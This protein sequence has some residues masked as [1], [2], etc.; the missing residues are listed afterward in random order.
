MPAGSA[1]GPHPSDRDRRRVLHGRLRRQPA[2]HLRARRPLRRARHGRRLAC[3]RLHGRQRPRHTR[4]LRRGRAHRHPHRH[5]RQGLRRRQRRLHRRA[6]RGRRLA[7]AALAALPLLQQHPA[8]GRGR[9]SCG[10][11]A[12]RADARAARAAPRECALLPR[13]AGATWLHA[14]AGRA[15]DHPGDAGRCGVG[16]AHGG[17]AAGARRV[18]DRLSYPVVPR[19]EARIR[20]QMSAALDHEQL[21][22]AVAA[23]REVG[24]QLGVIT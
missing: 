22:R 3:H 9:G 21:E 18:R 15:S 2:R 17:R 16:L 10:A 11:R 7:A 6:P 8:G 5:A 12:P 13:A 20:T 1:R 23:F 24:R 4:A 14:Q 19:G